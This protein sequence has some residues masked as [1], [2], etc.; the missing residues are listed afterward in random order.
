M[1]VHRVI[2]S[3]TLSRSHPSYRAARLLATEPLDA[4][5]LG[6]PAPIDPDMVVVWDDL[7]AGL[8]SQIAVSDGG[9]A[10][11]PFRPELKPV[12]AYCSAI[13][14]VIHIDSQAAQQVT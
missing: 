1:K 13:L 3:V 7:G 5:V 4:A 12:D 6:G 8:G 10:A 11:Q 14:D 9:E 2:G